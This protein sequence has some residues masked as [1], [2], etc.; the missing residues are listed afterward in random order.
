MQFDSIQGCPWSGWIV[1]P[2]AFC[3]ANLCA[4][5]R[6]PANTWSN[7]AFILVGVLIFKRTRSGSDSHF[8]GLGW[9]AIATGI[10]SFFYHASESRVGAIADYL[11][12]YLGSSYML[13]TNIHR[14]T[15][16]GTRVRILIFWSVTGVT[17][18]LMVFNDELARVVYGFTGFVSC[19]ALESA[20]Y[21]RNRNTRRAAHYQWLGA[22]W[23]CFGF[24]Y[25]VWKLDEA[26]ILCNPANHFFNGHALW[27]VLNAVALYLLFS[28][29]R[30]FTFPGKQ[31]HRKSEHAL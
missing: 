4:W 23:V 29:Y 31:Q 17:L 3:E 5:I 24:A 8:S 22:V 16:W 21:F 9:V 6:Q 20:I 15:G 2:T 7:I 1:S 30:Q 27:H 13:T 10:G 11:G 14:F 12:M 26:R 19:L 18:G 28:Y 25:L